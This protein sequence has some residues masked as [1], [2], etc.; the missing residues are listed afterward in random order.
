VVA[1][2]LVRIPLSGATPDAIVL[3]GDTAWVLTGEGGTLLEVD[4]EAQ[5]EVR[6][7]D[8][9]FGATHLALPL[10]GVAAVGRFDDSSTGGY[11]LMVSL[12][13]DDAYPVTTAELGSL[14]GGE[15][16][17]VWALEKADR[18]LK[19]DAA[20][21]AVLGSTA[22]EVGENV[23]VEVRWAGGAAWVGSDGLPLVRVDGDDLDD[24]RTIE[25]DEGIPFLFEGGLLWGAGPSQLWALDPATGEVTRRIA[26]EN[27][28]EILA[29]DI[30]GEEAWIA[31]RRPGHVGT[32][33]HLDLATEAVVGE[34]PIDLPAAVAIAPERVWVAS[35][36]TNELV[37]I[38][39]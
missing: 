14:S 13:T 2:A 6:S 12:E 11:C 23:H 15:D 27:L 33:L 3:D 8:V 34:V 21:G 19:I 22:V 36:S 26:L 37:G 17:V 28:I 29:L 18:L 24:H 4:L 38:E 31:A 1:G 32:V 16:G 7:I 39:R 20:T 35:Y 10:P 25:V 30:E 9:G 5:A